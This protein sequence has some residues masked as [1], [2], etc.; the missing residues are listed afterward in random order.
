MSDT[1]VLRSSISSFFCLVCPLSA[2]IWDARVEY[3][4]VRF[5]TMFL[6]STEA[7]ARF[8]R[9]S[10]VSCCMLSWRTPFA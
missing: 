10:I 2:L 4:V 6:S 3:A 7:D 9:A 5:A 8:S 1:L